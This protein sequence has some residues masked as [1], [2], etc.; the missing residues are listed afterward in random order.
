MGEEGPPQP[1]PESAA[2][3]PSE[4]PEAQGSV[5][6]QTTPEGSAA[7]TPGSRQTPPFSPEEWARRTAEA[8]QT[9]QQLAGLGGEPTVTN[10]ADG[11]QAV[12]GLFE[13]P[14]NDAASFWR[15]SGESDEKYYASLTPEQ[16]A[17]MV[18]FR[19]AYIE[20]IRGKMGVKD[21]AELSPDA[22]NV[23]DTTLEWLMRKMTR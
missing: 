16:Q 22:R 11:P 12:G 10:E 7:Q 5:L 19:D 1:P 14:T 13:K 3:S 4:V 18:K 6:G 15:R 20:L 9:R 23:F 17:E 8:D 2:A 21:T